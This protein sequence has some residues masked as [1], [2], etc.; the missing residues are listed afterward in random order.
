MT[1]DAVLNAWF[2]DGPDTQRT[3]WFT[4][5][6]AFDETL[7]TGFADALQEARQCALDGW[8]E[9]PSGALALIILLDQVARNI[10][11]GNPESFAGDAQALKLARRLAEAGDDRRLTPTQR[12]FAY[13]PFEHSEA[14]AD[15]DRSV[16]LFESMR[17]APEMQSV[18]DFAHRHRAVISRFGRFPHRNAI[19]GRV[20]TPEEVA[21]LAQPGAGF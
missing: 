2:T 12:I 16:A 9:T 3:A 21:Y 13:L 10:H 5:D 14:L 8:A 6:P 17:D 19:L 20:S 15:Q 1:P 11:R 4:K 7:R 18:I